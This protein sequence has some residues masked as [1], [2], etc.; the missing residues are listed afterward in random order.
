MSFLGCPVACGFT[1][2]PKYHL[3]GPN[4]KPTPSDAQSTSLHLRMG[5]MSTSHSAHFAFFQAKQAPKGTHQAKGQIPGNLVSVAQFGPRN[6]GDHLLGCRKGELKGQIRSIRL[7]VRAALPVSCSSTP[8]QLTSATM[9]TLG[10]L[11]SFL[12]SDRAD[13]PTEAT[14]FDACHD[15]LPKT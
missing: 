6:Q 5:T 3:G 7:Q 12:T 10:F 13:W 1:G 2:K 8:K 4:P 15:G 14:I 11:V 9:R